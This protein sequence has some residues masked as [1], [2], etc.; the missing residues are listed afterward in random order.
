M[1]D[2][3][4]AARIFSQI[5]MVSLQAT[6]HL[7]FMETS[8]ERELRIMS[9]SGDK[10][11]QNLQTPLPFNDRCMKD[12][13]KW[14]RTSGSMTFSRIHKEP[15]RKVVWSRRRSSSNVPLALL[16][17]RNALLRAQLGQFPQEDCSD[18][19]SQLAASKRGH[20]CTTVGTAACRVEECLGDSLRHDSV[21]L[22]WPSTRPQSLSD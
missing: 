10:A 21:M 20:S 9:N 18:K 13:Q 1:L 8:E 16:V 5:L 7:S 14:N 2:N 22:S 3:K 6:K 15:N 4:S 11:K 19:H 17:S 12:H